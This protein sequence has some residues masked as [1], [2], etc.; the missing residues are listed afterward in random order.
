[1]IIIYIWIFAFS[2][3]SLN[4][5]WVNGKRIHAEK[6]HPL[7][8][9]DSIKF[10]VPVIGD[11]VEFDY[12]LVQQ[13][14]RDVKVHLTKGPAGDA[15]PAHVTK[16]PKR[17]LAAEEVEPSTSKPKLYRCSSADKSLAKPCPLPPEKAQQR[18]SRCRTEGT[19]T[20]RQVQEVDESNSQ[21]DVDNLQM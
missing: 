4:G 11:N 21:C 3:Q 10:G 17:K 19:G 6:A 16:K 14:L 12:I 18:P 7:E 2:S 13:P 8:L 20:S 15:K 1:M 9:G 5:V